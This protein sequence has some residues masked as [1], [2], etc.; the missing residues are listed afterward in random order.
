MGPY[1]V[2][3]L[4]G[5]QLIIACMEGNFLPLRK[6]H[7]IAVVCADRAVVLHYQKIFESFGEG[8][9]VAD[10]AAMAVRFV[11]S[12]SWGGLLGGHI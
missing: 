6:N 10:K 11:G 9:T 8:N 4:V 3:K 12:T 2:S 7:E 5:L 1:L